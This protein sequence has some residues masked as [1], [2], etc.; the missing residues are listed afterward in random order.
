MAWLALTSRVPVPGAV[1]RRTGDLQSVYVLPA[2]RNHG[3]GAELVVAVKRAATAAGAERLVVHSSPRAVSA[4]DRAGFVSSELL[5][6]V[7]PG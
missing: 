6:D 3:I 5:R 1:D 7:M 2:L 4:Y